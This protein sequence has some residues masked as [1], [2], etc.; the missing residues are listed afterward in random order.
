M[1]VSLSRLT[2]LPLVFVGSSERRTV[3][4]ETVGVSPSETAPSSAD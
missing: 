1:T 3:P 2:L 4:P